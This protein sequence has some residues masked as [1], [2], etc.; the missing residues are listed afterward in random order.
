MRDM[1]TI[2][3]VGVYPVDALEPCHLLE[4]IVRG[5]EGEIDFSKFTQECPGEPR[6]NWQVPWDEQILSHSSGEVRAVFFLHYLDFE[7]PLLTPYGPVRL[8]PPS[9]KP[10]LLRNIEYDSP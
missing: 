1:T 3:V 7:Q 9:L 8:P 2:E 4:I 10:S 6:S 5:V